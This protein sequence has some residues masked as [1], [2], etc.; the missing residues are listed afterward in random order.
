MADRKR[1][2]TLIELLVV[3]AI[4]A[5]LAALIFPAFARAK[6]SAKQTQCISNLKQIGAAISLYMSDNDDFF[7]NAVD[8]SDK[9]APEIWSQYPKF[10]ARIP[11]M[12][13]MNEVL[14]PYIRDKG[15]WRCP[16]DKG[17]GQLDFTI[18]TTFKSSPTLHQVVGKGSS[19]FFRTEIAFLSMSSTR[20]ELPANVNVLFDGGGH[21]HG[22]GRQL[23]K[24]DIFDD[25]TQVVKDFRY[26][27]LYG[28]M[29]VKNLG[30]W[31]LQEAWDVPLYTGSDQDKDS[32]GG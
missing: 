32:Q 1:G 27:V 16:A 13:L 24:E 8:V 9:Y 19:Y 10:Q 4:I 31:Q 14:E 29:H 3:I 5:I 20:F 18:E 22:S 15:V 2:F 23:E 6:A 7:P 28:D 30:Y 26:N 25:W 17:T 12:P 21:W 11:Y